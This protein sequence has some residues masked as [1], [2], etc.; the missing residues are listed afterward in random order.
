MIILSNDIALTSS[1]LLLLLLLLLI[2]KKMDPSS[3]LGT[4]VRKPSPQSSSFLWVGSPLSF[5]LVS[6]VFPFLWR[7]AAALDARFAISL[8]R[9]LIVVS[10]CVAGSN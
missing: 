8:R 1:L 9:C 6:L 2:L 5:C 10:Y 4:Y 3:A 7:E